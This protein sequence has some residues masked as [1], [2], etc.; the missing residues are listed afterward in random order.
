M[1]CLYCGETSWR[2]FRWMADGE[3]CSRE[4]R[5]SYHQR[6]RKVVAELAECQS[7]PPDAVSASPNASTAI[8]ATELGRAT[9]ICGDLL[10]INASSI[11]AVAP[12]HTL[13]TPME[14][15]AEALL[16]V[17]V[18]P[19]GLESQSLLPLWTN[20]DKV[21]LESWQPVSVSSASGRTAPV[22]SV[23]GMLPAGFENHVRLKRWGLKIRFPKV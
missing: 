23:A 10:P 20:D 15:P 16:P 8:P 22:G 1:R 6:L 9:D 14:E 21:G 19:V 5:K 18:H 12:M 17:D 7:S 4:H 11:A 13:P 3:F 2:P